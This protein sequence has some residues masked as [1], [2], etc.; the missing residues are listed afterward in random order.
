VCTV[1]HKAS[2]AESV[3]MGGTGGDNGCSNWEQSSDT[4]IFVAFTGVVCT[5]KLTLRVKTWSALLM[6][7]PDLE[8]L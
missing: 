8:F 1:F 3:G 5:K 6:P 7:T 4:Y 2:E